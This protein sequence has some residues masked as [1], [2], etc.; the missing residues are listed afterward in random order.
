MHFYFS[1]DTESLTLRDI[2][3]NYDKLNNIIGTLSYYMYCK[4]HKSDVR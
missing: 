4:N 1:R 2:I 3:V